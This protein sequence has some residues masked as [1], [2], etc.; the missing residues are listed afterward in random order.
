MDT[1]IGCSIIIYDNDNKVLIAR[2]SS[3]KKKFPLMWE[4]IGGALENNETAE[5]CIRRE[6]M[7]EI[8]CNIFD[9]KL[10]KYY[11]INEDNRYILIVYTGKINEQIQ[12][13]SEIEQVR[14]ID[15]LEVE[16]YDFCGND[17]EKLLDYFSIN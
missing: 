9:L 5:E 1:Y 16:K 4:T 15:K 8:N 3:T 12:H 7:E 6:V 13:N 2:R 17:L 10:F 11:I 14:W